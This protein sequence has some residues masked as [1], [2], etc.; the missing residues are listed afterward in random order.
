MQIVVGLLCDCDGLLI[1]VEVFKGNTNDVKTLHGQIKKASKN[2]HVCKVVFIG[3]C[4]MIKKAQQDELSEADFDFITALT[5][6]Q[7]EKLIKQ[8]VI[9]LSLFDE[10]LSEIIL[11]NEKRYILKRNPI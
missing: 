11:E 1:L 8:N 3:D 5:K 2:F 10:R 9:Q 6:C 7:I 4:G